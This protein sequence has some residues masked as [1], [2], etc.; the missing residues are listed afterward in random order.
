[1]ATERLTAPAGTVRTNQYDG[2]SNDRDRLRAQA[3]RASVA[4]L[5]GLIGHGLRDG[6]RVL[7]VGCGLGLITRALAEAFPASEVT[8]LDFDPLAIAEARTGPGRVR[9]VEGD[10]HAMPF[11]DGAFDFVAVSFVLMHLV[12]PEQVI[13][14]CARV[15]APGGRL[16][17]IDT[18]DA[19]W[20]LDPPSPAF[21]ELKTLLG[22]WYA[23][24]GGSRHLGRRL[25]RMLARAGF[26]DVAFNTAAQTTLEI[27]QEA[28]D[29]TYLE[30]FRVQGPRMAAAGLAGVEVIS[31]LLNQLSVVAEG[32]YFGTISACFASGVK[33]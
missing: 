28:F 21:E 33:R 30:I 15:L 27:G 17:V 3:R 16:C 18:D 7:D 23:R 31:S 4:V 29:R 22:Q 20:L 11:E 25:P 1:M 6:M 13:R 24:S 32:G 26:S 9:F 12:H 8:G 19:L 5:K 2:A 14:E 10:A